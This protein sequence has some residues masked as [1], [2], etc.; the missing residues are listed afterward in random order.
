MYKW[1]AALVF[2]IVFF[3]CSSGKYN[4]GDCCPIYWFIYYF[5]FFGSMF[6]KL[7]FV[8]HVQAVIFMYLLLMGRYNFFSFCKW[9]NYNY[10]QKGV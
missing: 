2:I 6:E 7:K 1:L 8:T 4:V 3:F 5:F 9:I 10:V